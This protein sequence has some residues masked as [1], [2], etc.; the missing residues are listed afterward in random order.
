MY[1]HGIK[2]I[3]EVFSEGVFHVDSDGIIHLLSQAFYR[4]LGIGSASITLD[5]WIQLIHPL[6]RSLFIEQIRRHKD[7]PDE[8]LHV[9]YR[10]RRHNSQYVWIEDRLIIWEDNDHKFVIGCHKDISDQ[11]LMESYL[12]QVAFFDAISGLYNRT[13]LLHDL[14]DI[15]SDTDNNIHALIYIQI[16]NIKSYLN[17]Y[18]SEILQDFLDHVVDAFREIPE[19]LANLYRVRLDDFAILL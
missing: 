7:L 10:L 15:V 3:F 14:G 18:G 11:K 9:Q 17:Q 1:Q 12:Q 19:E 4:Q 13:K 6:D 8:P 5:D 16:D 2:Y